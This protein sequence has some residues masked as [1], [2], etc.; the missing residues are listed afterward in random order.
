MLLCQLHFYIHTHK[1]KIKHYVQGGPDKT[2][3]KMQQRESNNLWTFK[4]DAIQVITD[5]ILKVRK[6]RLKQDE[7]KKMPCPCVFFLQYYGFFFLSLSRY[8]QASSPYTTWTDMMSKKKKTIMLW[9]LQQIVLV[10]RF[11][12]S[13]P[14]PRHTKTTCWKC[15]QPT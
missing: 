4:Q 1:P 5:M 3:K 10:S 2:N 8:V 13:L 14:R 11:V 7:E 6:Q 9:H 15:Y 12:Q